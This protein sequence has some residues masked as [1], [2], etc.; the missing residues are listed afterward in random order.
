[1]RIAIYSGSFDIITEGHLWMIKTG[2]KLFDK[3][4][5]GIGTNPNKQNLFDFKARK[6]L[7]E[8]ICA[9]LSDNLVIEDFSN[10]ALVQFAHDKNA[11]YI[12]RGIRSVSDFD[13]ERTLKNVNSD[14]DEKIETVFLMPPR[15]LSEVSSSMV[16]GMLKIKGW[17]LI[18]KRYVPETMRSALIVRF[19][20]DPVQIAEH[21][22]N[23][24][25]SIILEEYYSAKGRY[26][27][28]L[29]HIENC[30]CEFRE[31]EEYITDYRSALIALLFHDVVYDP[32]AS[33]ALANEKA[34]WELAKKVC[35]LNETT[36]AA[37]KS[38]ILHSSHCFSSD[39]Y[40][41]TDYICDIDMAI[42]GYSEAE[43]YQYEANIHREYGFLSSTEYKTGRIQ[44]LQNILNCTAIYKTRYFYNKYEVKARANIE[45]LITELSM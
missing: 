29:K 15:H 19:S 9:E 42:L 41:D 1:M 35:R 45:R 23:E 37:I 7:L 4:I 43:F 18:I 26:Y 14:L 28:N 22:I 33:Q 30:L 12:L 2:I 3:L 36:D 6:Q 34:S 17:E 11:S 32:K 16:K 5:V 24:P 38:H 27:H 8:T 10:L 20:S 31:I 44:F 13:Y 25:A 40:S 39:K 21:Y